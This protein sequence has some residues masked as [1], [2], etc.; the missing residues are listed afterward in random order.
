MKQDY[1]RSGFFNLILALWY[2]NVDALKAWQQKSV[3][4]YQTLD[5]PR[6]A[7]FDKPDMAPEVDTMMNCA[8]PAFATVGLFE[9]SLSLMAALG[10][11]WDK[12]GLGRIDY[13]I[14]KSPDSSVWT[15]VPFRKIYYRLVLFLSSIPGTIDNAEVEAIMPSPRELAD[16]ERGFCMGRTWGGFDVT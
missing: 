13:F 16:I 4:I 1:F 5:L 2:G 12:D 15:C 8:V 7:W 10:Y 6:Y 3:E 11:T 14:N 9:E